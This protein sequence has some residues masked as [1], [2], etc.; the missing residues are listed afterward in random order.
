[1]PINL[2]SVMILLALQLL[3]FG[4]R[5]AREVNGQEPH[6]FPWVPVPDNVNVAS[7]LAVLYACVLVPVRT[8]SPIGES[9]VLAPIGRAVFA[10]AALLIVAYPLVVAA[11]Y[12]LWS[13]TGGGSDVA[14]KTERRYCSRAEGLVQLIALLATGAVFFQVLQSGS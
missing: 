12:G 9:F 7:M 8:L 2:Q 11:H 10:A 6:S 1:M 5:I 14:E 3:V 13:G 4:W